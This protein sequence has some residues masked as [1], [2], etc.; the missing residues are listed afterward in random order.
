[1]THEDNWS[2]LFGLKFNLFNGGATKAELSKLR[3]RSEQIREERKKLV[4]EIKLEVERYY[5]DEKSSRDNLLATKEAIKQAEENLRINRVRYEEGVGTAT[6]V[7]DAISLFTLAHKNYYKAL[8]DMKR[9]HA[10]LL[11]AI[12]DDLTLA[13]K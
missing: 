4:D 13:Y 2:V 1:V 11:Y 3:Y 5:L 9:A 10:G 7:L 8:Y 6:D 12:G